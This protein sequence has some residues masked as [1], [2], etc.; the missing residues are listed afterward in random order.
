[1]TIESPEDRSESDLWVDADVLIGTGEFD[2]AQRLLIILCDRE[3]KSARDH[4]HRNAW[5][6]P[7]EQL[8]TIH[9]LRQDVPGAI[10]ILRRC[11]S[12]SESAADFISVHLERLLAGEVAAPRSELLRSLTR[13]GQFRSENGT[14]YRP[15]PRNASGGAR[16]VF[17]GGP[18]C[19]VDRRGVHDCVTGER[20]VGDDDAQLAEDVGRVSTLAD[21]DTY[22]LTVVS[23][24]RRLLQLCERSGDD[25]AWAYASGFVN[26][27]FREEV[28]AV[29]GRYPTKRK[30]LLLRKPS[31]G[32]WLYDT[33]PAVFVMSEAHN[34]EEVGVESP[35]RVAIWR[36]PDRS[37]LIL[38]AF[39]ETVTR[40]SDEPV[41]I[42]LPDT[43]MLRDFARRYNAKQKMDRVSR[44]RL[45]NFIQFSLSGS[46]GGTA[47]Y[48]RPRAT[49]VVDHDLQE[50]DGDLL[51]AA[52]DYLDT[53]Y[54]LRIS[55]FDM[56]RE[57]LLRSQLERGLLAMRDRR[58][59][60][61]A[62]TDKETARLEETRVWYSSR[63]G[64]ESKE[65]LFR[66][67][68]PWPLA[69]ES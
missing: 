28:R 47:C 52:L 61:A 42:V 8:A 13:D 62:W 64:P 1:M 68:A 17:V 67:H 10:S 50:W 45:E 22:A 11:L 43:P 66:I 5:H 6:W 3:E 34:R 69:A 31:K 55:A 32:R 33:D 65:F 19:Y 18:M 2:Q 58:E 20:V 38:H 9:E 56:L 37:D 44:T 12:V 57:P 25:E 24:T 39:C 54:Q 40:G 23:L 27:R 29:S 53:H 51:V 7:F 60:E 36:R 4:N 16:F 35:P 41:C 63:E 14:F 21:D 49:L 15:L 26:T 30:E 48:T 46:M 59:N